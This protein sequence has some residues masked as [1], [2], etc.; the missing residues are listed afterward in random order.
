MCDCNMQKNE[1]IQTFYLVQNLENVS[2][3]CHPYSTA[4]HKIKNAK[5]VFANKNNTSVTLNT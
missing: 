5:N 4:N 3:A 1:A 2:S